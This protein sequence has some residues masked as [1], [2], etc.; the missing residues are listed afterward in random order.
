MPKNKANHS[1]PFTQ[2]FVQSNLPRG[3]GRWM[4]ASTPQLFSIPTQT[5]SPSFC[6]VR[7]MVVRSQGSYLKWCF[8]L[9]TRGSLL[10]ISSGTTCAP[11]GTS[12][13]YHKWCHLGTRGGQKVWGQR[14]SLCCQ[15][16]YEEHLTRL[17]TWLL[18]RLSFLGFQGFTVS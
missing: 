16:S 11:E 15:H 17:I 3:M 2:S 5:S 8:H 18:A 6:G 10:V 12:T 7:S 9:C 13:S 4:I 1:I 14:W